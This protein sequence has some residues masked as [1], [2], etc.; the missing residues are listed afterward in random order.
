M[1][2]S[3]FNCRSV[4]NKTE[5][6]RDMIIE[7]KMD[8]FGLTETWLKQDEKHII[9]EIVPDGYSYNSVPRADGSAGGLLLVFK[10]K[11]QC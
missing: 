9:G 8:I 2:V 11:A 5:F 3:V 7:N 6:L 10:S 4:R 1:K